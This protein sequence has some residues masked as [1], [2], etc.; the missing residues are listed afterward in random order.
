MYVASKNVINSSVLEIRKS[1]EKNP[2]ILKSSLLY[3]KNEKSKTFSCFTSARPNTLHYFCATLE[4][5]VYFS[6]DC[7]LKVKPVAQA[8]ILFP[9]L[10]C[11][12]YKKVKNYI[13]LSFENLR[14]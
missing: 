6:S 10:F 8:V 14:G 3:C 4:P 9:L 11:A 1:K 13:H 5:S 12:E 2:T 7:N